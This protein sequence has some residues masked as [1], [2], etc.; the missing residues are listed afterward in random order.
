MEFNIIMGILKTSLGGKKKTQHD[1]F[2]TCLRFTDAM[3]FIQM[4]LSFLNDDAIQAGGHTGAIPRSRRF[5]EHK[6]T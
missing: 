4:V 3:T 5:E 2:K 6:V 1:R